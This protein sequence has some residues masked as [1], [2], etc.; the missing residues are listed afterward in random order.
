MSQKQLEEK[1]CALQFGIYQHM[2]CYSPQKPL[3]FMFKPFIVT[4][5]P[6]QV[7]QTLPSG[8]EEAILRRFSW[9]LLSVAYCASS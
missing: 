4:P 9:S 8:E 5:H 7:P 3:T 6:A 1:H 2:H